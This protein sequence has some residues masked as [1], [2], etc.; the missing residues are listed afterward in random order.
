[1]GHKAGAN[2]HICKATLTR[3]DYGGG[4]GREAKLVYDVPVEN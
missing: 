3:W 4:E 2:L 1:V